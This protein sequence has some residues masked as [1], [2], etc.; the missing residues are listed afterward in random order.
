MNNQDYK[1][2]PQWAD[3]SFQQ[4]NHWGWQVQNAVRSVSRL[5]NILATFTEH[6]ATSSQAIEKVSRDLFQFKITP[7]MILSLKR[8]LEANIRGAWEAFSQ[9][10]LPSG[11]ELA[12]E[13]TGNFGIDCIGEELPNANPVP[14]ITN[15]YKNRVLF[16]VTSLCPAYCR[17]CFRRRM[18]GEGMGA[19][20]EESI[21]EGISYIANNSE[22]HEVI[23]SGGD[24]LVLS[25]E[26]LSFI[27]NSLRA[28]PHIRRL[29]IDSKALTMMPQRITDAF[30][31]IL[32]QYKPLYFIGHFSHLHEL[33]D[34]TKTACARLADAGIPL[35]S[36]TPLLKGVSDDKQALALLMETLVDCRVQPYYLIHFIP[37]KWTQ[38][39]RVPLSHGVEL[40][41]HL[42]RSCGGLA[43]PT[44]IVYLPEGGGK[45]PVAPQYIIEQN[46]EGYLFKNLDGRV[47]LYPEYSE[48]N[49]MPAETHHELVLAD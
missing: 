1:S 10:F 28:I 4:W 27:L 17:Y 40:I 3:V 48:I 45:V 43:T 2:L 15:F 5:N 49:A 35:G 6:R 20:N 12:R 8:A 44:L 9:S 36:H 11:L 26:R 33:T 19:W 14:A 46:E 32:R 30:V 42:F 16:R 39:F 13:N 38:H 21:K 22:I 25:D 47:I 41:S 23:L 34:E 7:H 29:R 37:T 31:E 24:P 18:V